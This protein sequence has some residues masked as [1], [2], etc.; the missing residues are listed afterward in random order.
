MATPAAE[1]EAS[2]G[3]RLAEALAELEA[4]KAALA[5]AR[6]T[7]AAQKDD[8]DKAI[9]GLAAKL[10]AEAEAA[11]QHAALYREAKESHQANLTEFASRDPANTAT[12]S[13]AR[14]ASIALEEAILKAQLGTTRADAEAQA[15]RVSD[16][17]ETI[18]LIQHCDTMVK[19]RNEKASR[20]SCLP[21][22]GTLAVWLLAAAIFGSAFYWFRE[23]ECWNNW[24][25]MYFLMATVTT[26]GYGDQGGFPKRSGC[27][28]SHSADADGVV[29][30]EDSKYVTIA[31]AFIGIAVVGGL[32]AGFVNFLLEQQKKLGQKMSSRLMRVANITAN[33]AKAAVHQDGK[34]LVRRSSLVG[35]RGQADRVITKHSNSAPQS[36]NSVDAAAKAAATTV[37]ATE[38]AAAAAA[39]AAS[40]SGSNKVVPSSEESVAVA[41]APAAAMDSVAES[42]LFAEQRKLSEGSA[43][44]GMSTLTFAVKLAWCF[45]PMAIFWSAGVALGHYVEEW[46]FTNSAYFSTISMLTI[47]YGDLAPTTERG[48]KLAIAYLPFAVFAT[49]A[50]LSNIMALNQAR[51]VLATCDSPSEVLVGAQHMLSN[52]RATVV[53]R[54]VVCAPAPATV[55]LPPSLLLTRPPHPP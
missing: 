12:G 37:A 34:E 15:S 46:S 31:F 42:L 32:L 45:V 48:R 49:T 21:S 38:P 26:V 54:V 36:E 39:A 53:S 50:T 14:R 10:E 17:I 40:K 44:Q 47:G 24:D 1:A 18:G 9:K 52:V 33:K 7:A 2:S 27:T 3:S 6:A 23:T 19:I 41:V 51:A 55:V 28:V 25:T 30:S 8:H 29:I 5:E 11:R 4:A 22:L 13:K 16:P 20:C 35:M 43:P